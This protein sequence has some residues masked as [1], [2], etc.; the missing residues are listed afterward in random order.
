[1]LSACSLALQHGAAL[2]GIEPE[3]AAGR[4]RALVLDP[5]RGLDHVAHAVAELQV[6]ARGRGQR[7]VSAAKAAA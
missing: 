6:G 2:A 5:D 1:M 7:A 3:P 4:G